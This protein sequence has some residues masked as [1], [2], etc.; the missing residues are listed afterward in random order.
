MIEFHSDKRGLLMKEKN[1]GALQKIWACLFLMCLIVPLTAQESVDVGFAEINLAFAE[2]SSEKVSDTLKKYTGSPNYKDYESYAL[3]KTRQLIIEDEL[4]LARQMSLAVID[5][6]LEN[7]DAVELYS[8]I[9]RAILNEQAAKQAE[10]NRLRLEAERLAAMNE[11]TKVKIEKSNAYQTL[12]TPKGESV[13]VRDS[14]QTFSTFDWR[15]SLGLC[16]MLFV[17]GGDRPS[18]NYGLGFG[19]DLFY[20]AESFSIG[21]DIFADFQ[22]LRFNKQETDAQ[23]VF[24]SLRFVPMIAI[25][26]LSKNVFF[27]MGFATYGI[28]SGSDAEEKVR[29]SDRLS[30]MTPVFGI[31]LENF[32]LG[33]VDI[34][35]HYD[36]YLGHFA[37]DM[38][39]SM[40]FGGNVTIPLAVN[41]R[42]KIGIKLGASD[43]LMVKNGGGVENRVKGIFAIGVGNVVR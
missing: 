37:Y 17:L 42:T 30:F 33:P 14:E 29:S 13:Y 40:E 15:L 31:G 43:L 5:N 27:R 28:A 41:E 10:E 24:L 11:K 4:E 23:E 25:N 8:Y 26:G 6:N 19:A 7:F 9:D 3:K 12:S 21:A 18:I 39:T 2:K 36:Y 32:S 22:M 20:N 38:A 35:A 1:C 16:D 34:C